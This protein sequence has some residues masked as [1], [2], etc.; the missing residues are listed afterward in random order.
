ML[1]PAARPKGRFLVNAAT[2]HTVSEQPEAAL[3]TQ[4]RC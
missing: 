2:Y 1:F 4:Q 3:P